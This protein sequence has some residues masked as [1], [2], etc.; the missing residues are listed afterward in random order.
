MFAE[1][2]DERRLCIG[3]CGQR[4]KVSLDTGPVHSK[5]DGS[6]ACREILER[7]T[8]IAEVP[9]KVGKDIQMRVLAEPFRRPRF[10]DVKVGPKV[11]K[12]VDELDLE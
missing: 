8:Q 6:H 2:F 1:V 4:F 5:I 12:E 3:A 10:V 11:T 9:T 7:W